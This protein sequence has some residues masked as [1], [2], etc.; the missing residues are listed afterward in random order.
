MRSASSLAVGFV[1]LIGRLQGKVKRAGE[2]CFSSENSF[3]KVETVKAIELLQVSY[4]KQRRAIGYARERGK[5]RQVEIQVLDAQGKLM[6]TVGG[7]NQDQRT[8]ADYH[9]CCGCCFWLA[10]YSLE[11]MAH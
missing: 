11:F 7:P 2:A 6:K 4:L 3:L 8:G 9:G 1:F 10:K 5:R